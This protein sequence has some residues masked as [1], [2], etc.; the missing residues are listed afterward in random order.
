MSSVKFAYGASQLIFTAQLVFPLL[1]PETTTQA[2]VQLADGGWRAETV[3]QSNQQ[4]FELVWDAMPYT[5]VTS[6]SSWINNTVNWGALAFTYYDPRGSAYGVRMVI[7]QEFSPEWVEY[8]KY[9][10]RLRLRKEV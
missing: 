6:L 3:G 1:A 9:R 10:V 7:P 8:N 5:E 2:A 4:E